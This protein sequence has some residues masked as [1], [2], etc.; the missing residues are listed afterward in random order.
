MWDPAADYIL[1]SFL[2]GEFATTAATQ[3]DDTDDNRNRNALFQIVATVKDTET[4]THT[5]TLTCEDV[6]FESVPFS[7]TEHEFISRDLKGTAADFSVVYS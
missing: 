7:L 6:Y 5:I 1:W 2:S 3:V 4:G